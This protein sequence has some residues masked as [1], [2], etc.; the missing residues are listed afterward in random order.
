MLVRIISM[1]IAGV[2]IVYLAVGLIIFS[3]GIANKSCLQCKPNT[4]ICFPL[5]PIC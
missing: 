5:Q 3:P 4:P 2:I 1:V